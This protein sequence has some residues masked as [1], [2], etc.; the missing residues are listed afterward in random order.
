[1]LGTLH[2]PRQG[3][4]ADGQVHSILLLTRRSLYKLFV[5]FGDVVRHDHFIVAAAGGVA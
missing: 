2:A 1:V 5:D 4:G 3:P